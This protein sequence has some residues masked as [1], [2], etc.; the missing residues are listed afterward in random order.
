MIDV[1]ESTFD[2]FLRYG[3]FFGAIFQL[4]CIGAAIFGP[5]ISESHSK[6]VCEIQLHFLS[7]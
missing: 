4:V 1:E 2:L 3:L 5:D 6:V 7:Y